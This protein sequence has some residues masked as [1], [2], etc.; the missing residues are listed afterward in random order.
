MLGKGIRENIVVWFQETFGLP[1]EGTAITGREPDPSPPLS[2][3]L[4]IRRMYAEAA[5]GG[6][7]GRSYFDVHTVEYVWTASRNV[8][9]SISSAT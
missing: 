9:P 6:I 3:S 5:V 7:M 1:G 8:S 4:C 2:T